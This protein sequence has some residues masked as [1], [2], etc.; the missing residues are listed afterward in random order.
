MKTD[1][2]IEAFKQ[3]MET[4]KGNVYGFHIADIWGLDSRTDE[5]IIA[6]GLASGEHHETI[7]RALTLLKN[8]EGMETQV[9]GKGNW[10]YVDGYNAAIDELKSKME[11]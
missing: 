7:L 4:N 8:Y 10:D 3:A 2:A 9:A 11:E 5:L 6:V 1:D